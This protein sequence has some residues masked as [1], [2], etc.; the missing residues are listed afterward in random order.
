MIR[1]LVIATHNLAKAREIAA[2]L[3][4][5]GLDLKT[6]TLR[7][8]P[9]L[10]LPEEG[11]ESFESNA[12]GKALA[13]WQGTGKP[14]LG[15]DSGLEVEALGGRPGV[16]SSRFAGRGAGQRELCE[17]VLRL[18]REAPEEGRAA[19]F[20]SVCAL[21]LDGSGTRVFEGRCEG[22]IA[23]EMRGSGGFGYDPI[24]IPFGLAP[25]DYAQGKQGRPG[26]ERRTMAELSAEEKNR[27]SH[28]GKAVRALAHAL[29]NPESQIS[30][31]RSRI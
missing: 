28:R 15:E 23:R 17:K 1:E 10:I 30:D 16:F 22:Q 21:A 3:A 11:T 29:R 20:R 18:M 25:L 13:C 6:L 5:Q 7:D 27:M 31:L 9:E 14:S 24:F 19:R 2:I 8:L 12:R 26:G 4:E